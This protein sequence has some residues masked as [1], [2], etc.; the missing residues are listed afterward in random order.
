MEFLF[1]SRKFGVLFIS[2]TLTVISFFGLGMWSS[3]VSLHIFS[4]LL[5]GKFLPL[6]EIIL[7]SIKMSWNFKMFLMFLMFRVRIILEFTFSLTHISTFPII[8]SKPEI[9]TSISCILLDNVFSVLP[10]HN[11]T[12]FI[13]RAPST[14]ILFMDSLSI[15]R[16][17]TFTIDIFCCLYVLGFLHGLQICCPEFG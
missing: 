7:M 8:S 13:S 4:G 11:P 10:V 3:V 2:C 12:F 14:C 9:L 16:S 5:A 1:C 15:F 6:N 17:W